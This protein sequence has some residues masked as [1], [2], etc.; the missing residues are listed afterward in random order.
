MLAARVDRGMARSL[1]YNLGRKVG[2]K[3]RKAKWVWESLTGTETDTIRL[4]RHVGLDLVQEARTQLQ[5]DQDPGTRRTLDDIGGRLAARVAN[6]LRSFHFDVFQAGEPNAFALPGGFI[7]ASR[8]ILALCQADADQI[9]FV[10]G[11]EM[12]HVI[13]GHAME[14]IV[15]NSAISAVSQVAPVRGVLGPWLR[16]VGVRFL[17][18]AYSRDQELD[19]DRLAVRLAGAAGFEPH[20]GIRLLANLAELQQSSDPLSLGQYLCTHP[21]F[22]V[23]INNVRQFLS[24]R[25]S[26][27]S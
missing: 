14:R 19:A 24:K 21:S 15:A 22:D 26:S 25:S 8:S 6:K 3:V 18:T 5:L 4:E 2:P 20:G 11:H 1:F 23:R 9:A 10:L 27:S 17:E 13:R 16:R 7:F 12:S